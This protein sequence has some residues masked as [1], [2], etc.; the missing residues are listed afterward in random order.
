MRSAIISFHLSKVLHLPRKRETRLYEVLHLSREIILSN[1]GIWCSKIQPLSGNQ[2]QDLLTCL[3]H[4]SL[5][6]PLP[7]KSIFAD[8]LQ[9]P[10]PC[11]RFWNSCK[12]ITSTSKLPRVL[13]QWS[14]LSILTSKSASRHN[15]VQ[16]FISYLLRWFCARCFSEPTFRPSRAIPFRAPA[17]SFFWLFLLT[18]S[19]LWSS[20]FFSSL[21]WLFPPLLFHLS[22]LSVVWLLNFLW[23]RSIARFTQLPSDNLRW[24]WAIQTF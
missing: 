6:L 20:F 15:G 18:L 14:V 2:R 10:H 23:L 22:I 8:P 24:Q 17:S 5:V 16:F 12:T 9:M 3:T 21:L 1:L 11:Q 4:V 13:R 7:G 19:L